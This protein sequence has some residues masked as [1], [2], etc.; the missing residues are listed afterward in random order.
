[1]TNVVLT[2]PTQAEKGRAC[3]KKHALPDTVGFT[4]SIS[5]LIPSLCD[6]IGS[7]TGSAGFSPIGRGRIRLHRRSS[8][9]CCCRLYADNLKSSVPCFSAS[10]RE[11]SNAFLS[12][13]ALAPPST[14]RAASFF[15]FFQDW[16]RRREASFQRMFCRPYVV[17]KAC[18]FYRKRRKPP[19]FRYG[20]I[21]RLR[22]QWYLDSGIIKAY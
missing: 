5:L 14:R 21:R 16:Q 1:M 9:R 7:T 19:I 3:P 8:R 22:L 2:W 15:S 11:L 10:R 13:R 12:N 4:N 17:A 6:S 20:D 18:F